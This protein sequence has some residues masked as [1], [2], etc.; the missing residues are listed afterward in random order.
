MDPE[1]E[2]FITNNHPTKGH[3]TMTVRPTL[4]GIDG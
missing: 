3:L 4:R 1:L 2:A